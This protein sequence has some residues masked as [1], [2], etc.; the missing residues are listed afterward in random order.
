MA[1]TFSATSRLRAY[2]IDRDDRRCAGDSGSLDA[3]QSKRPASHDGDDR[4]WLD[5]RNRLSR[6]GAQSGDADAAAD[7]AEL[8]GIG[9]REDGDHPFFERDHD[10]GQPA[11]VRVRIDGRAVTHLGDRHEIVRALTTEE[12]THVRA[13]AKALIAGAALRRA[14]DAHAIADLHATHLGADSLDDADAAVA[15]DQRHRAQPSAEVGS[16]PEDD[17]GVRVAEIGGFRADDHLTAA[18][19]TKRQVLERR[20]SSA[21]SA[22]HPSTKRASRWTTRHF[23]TARWRERTL[24]SA[25][26]CRAPPLPQRRVPFSAGSDVRVRVLDIHMDLAIRD[27]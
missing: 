24:S 17:A 23:A 5:Q 3:A 16:E 22:R 14:G 15:L 4:S 6:G 18:D 19:R 26:G 7:H 8:G 10:L 27:W 2:R 1:P 20:A 9:L 13:P 21:A 25:T 11:D 12:L